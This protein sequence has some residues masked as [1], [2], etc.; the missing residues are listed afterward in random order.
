MTLLG[1]KMSNAPKRFFKTPK[2]D[3]GSKL[4]GENSKLI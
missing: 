4:L 1:S 3:N 2:L